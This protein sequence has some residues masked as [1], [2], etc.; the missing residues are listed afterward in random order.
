MNAANVPFKPKPAPAPPPQ[1]QDR[2]EMIRQQ[3]KDDT[4]MQFAAV[5]LEGTLERSKKR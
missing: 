3:S 1:P 2:A 4:L 5:E